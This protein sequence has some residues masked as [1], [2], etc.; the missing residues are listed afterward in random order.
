[1]MRIISFLL[2]WSL[3]GFSACSSQHAQSK[4]QRQPLEKPPAYEYKT[5]HS[6]APRV[7]SYN[8]KTG[9]P[10]T[11]D[12]KRRVEVVDAKAGKYAFN[13]IGFD[14]REKAA[15]FYRIDAVDVLVRASA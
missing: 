15:T 5:P 1:M 4:T 12:H 2:S 9:E 14:G 13:W 10:I 7:R 3:L 11:Y 8:P 6:Y